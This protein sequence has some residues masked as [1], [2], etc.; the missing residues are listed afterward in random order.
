MQPVMREFVHPLVV[1]YG[2]LQASE[3]FLCLFRG[4]RRH[5]NARRADVMLARVLWLADK[6]FRNGHQPTIDAFPLARY[7]RTYFT[8]F[9]LASDVPYPFICSITCALVQLCVYLLLVLRDCWRCYQQ[10]YLPT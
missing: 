5:T 8:S 3:D 2:D 10:D 4:T 9:C 7:Y 1:A 6:R